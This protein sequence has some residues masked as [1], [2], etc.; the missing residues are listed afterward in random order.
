MCLQYQP[1]QDL[2]HGQM[3]IQF[4]FLFELYTPYLR[5]LSQTLEPLTK[6]LALLHRLSLVLFEIS[7]AVRLAASFGASKSGIRLTPSLAPSK[8]LVRVPSHDL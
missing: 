6:G 3:A 2:F 1:G 5:T 4:R 8:F 7:S